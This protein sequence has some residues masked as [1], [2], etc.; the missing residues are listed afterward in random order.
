ILHESGD[1]TLSFRADQNPWMTGPDHAVSA[2]V[3]LPGAATAL[4]GPV[5]TLPK[6]TN[7]FK[8]NQFFVKV[9]CY[10]N[11][12]VRDAQ[13]ALAPGKPVF[14]ELPTAAFWVQRG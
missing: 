6:E 4:K 11:Y 1:W 8:R 13:P 2:S 12:P 9:R 7:G 10:G 14:F 3:V 5:P